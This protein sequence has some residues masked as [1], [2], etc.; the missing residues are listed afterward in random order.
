MRDSWRHFVAELIGTFALVF[1]GGASIMIARDTNSPAGL[2]A[3]AFAHGLILAV[4]VS[5]LMRISGHFNPAVTIG[6]LAT[7]RIEPLMAGVYI[8]AQV[9]GAIVAA[10]VLKFTFPFTLFEVTR[11]GGQAIA[12]QVSGGQAFLLEAVATFLLVI[13]VF[14]TAVDPKA[15]KVGGL[16]IGFVVA[17]DILAI[18]PLTG[19]SM[20]PAR[21]FGPAVASGIFEAQAIYWLAPITGAVIAAVLYEYLF[22]RREME[23]ELHG[24]LRPSAT[25]GE[26]PKSHDH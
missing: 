7:R 4:M 9:I 15:P 6:F 8:L 19:A 3:I 10:Y 26:R 1:V 25:T 18:G 24:T 22:L 11:G 21:S 23:P 13:T 2:V 14:G 5:A 16:A 20:N 17:A 12:L